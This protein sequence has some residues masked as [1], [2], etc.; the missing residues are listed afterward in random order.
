[1]QKSRNDDFLFNSGVMPLVLRDTNTK[2]KLWTNPSP[3]GSNYVRPLGQTKVKDD[4]EEVIKWAVK[5]EEDI[6]NLTVFETEM[7]EKKISVTYTVLP[8]MQDGKQRKAI[9]T[10]ALR[11]AT[12][13]GVKMKTHG[14]PQKIDYKTCWVCLQNPQL[15]NLPQSA[16]FL[17][18]EPW[19]SYIIRYGM[20]PM[21][22]K[23]RTMEELMK[24]A[25]KRKIA[26]EQKRRKM[27]YSKEYM[28]VRKTVVKKQMQRQFVEECGGL[29]IDFPDKKVRNV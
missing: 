14:N 17:P 22:V 15:Y 16:N 29:R 3:G 20:S 5:H 10:A 18:K 4:E 26:S 28:K 7:D 21:H 2:E 13:K 11:E 9:Y 25:Q 6:Q 12:V 1:M 27:Q 24:T 19:F 8:V 23:G